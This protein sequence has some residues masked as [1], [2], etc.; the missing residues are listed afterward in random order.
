MSDREKVDIVR[1]L[2]MGTATPVVDPLQ[3]T[4]ATTLRASGSGLVNVLAATTSSVYPTVKGARTIR[5]R[6]TWGWHEGWHSTS[7]RT[8]SRR[9]DT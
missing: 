2:I 9:G 3:D 5:P 1:D 6:P 7:S 4:G 8:T